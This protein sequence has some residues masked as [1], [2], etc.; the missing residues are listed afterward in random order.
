M[1]EARCV[2]CHMPETNYMVVDARRDHSLRGIG[3]S[4]TCWTSSVPKPAAA[5]SFTAHH[6]LPTAL[7]IGP[8]SNFG[9]A[10]ERLT[11]HRIRAWDLPSV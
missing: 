2:E 7:F 1:S 8:K 10:L 5:P 11:S 6:P 3:T 4:G 9:T